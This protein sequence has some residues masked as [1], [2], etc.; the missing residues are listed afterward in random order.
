MVNC[1]ALLEKILQLGFTEREREGLT[2]EQ[3]FMNPK[4]RMKET[5]LRSPSKTIF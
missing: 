5:L 2:G 4:E 1:N 3:C